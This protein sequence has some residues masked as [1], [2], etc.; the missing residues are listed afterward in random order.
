MFP[1]VVLIIA[2]I[3]CLYFES[4]TSK[5][6]MALY[7]GDTKW[8]DIN[9]CQFNSFLHAFVGNNNLNQIAVRSLYERMQKGEYYW[10]GLFGTLSMPDAKQKIKSTDT[11]YLPREIFGANLSSI[12]DIMKWNHPIYKD[13]KS[14]LFLLFTIIPYLFDPYKKINNELFLNGDLN[15]EYKISSIESEDITAC[16]YLSV[17]NKLFYSYI[18]LDFEVLFIGHVNICNNSGHITVIVKTGKNEYTYYDDNGGGI[19]R[20]T[21]LFVL[22][23]KLNKV[24]ALSYKD[25]TSRFSLHC[26]TISKTSID[27]I[28]EDEIP[29]VNTNESIDLL[30]LKFKDNIESFYDEIL[31]P[32]YKFGNFYMLFGY[33][34]IM[35]KMAETYMVYMADPKKRDATALVKDLDS[36][37]EQELSPKE[38]EEQDAIALVEQESSL[39]PI[40]NDDYSEA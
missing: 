21:K 28:F 37:I 7:Q 30:K 16:Y 17:I 34:S 29:E 15:S 22:I 27:T 11:C 18:Q 6:G 12:I 36:F 4:A 26:S 35:K 3:L 40:D 14:N 39:S 38:D 1:I 10:K 25:K 8:D 13:S 33:R 24:L 20:G 23:Y 32:T 2:V 5:G 19:I 9:M 31:V